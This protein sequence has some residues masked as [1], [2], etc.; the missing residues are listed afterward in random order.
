[1]VE[2]TVNK[3]VQIL[4][5]VGFLVAS[6]SSGRMMDVLQ[7]SYCANNSNYTSTL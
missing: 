2:N 3:G 4:L 6:Y 5:T 1:M 7:L